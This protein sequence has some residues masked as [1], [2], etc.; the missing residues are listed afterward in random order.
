[1]AMPKKDQE[2]ATYAWMY[3]AQARKDG[4]EREVPAYWQEHANA[5]LQGFDGVAMDGFGKTKT[6]NDEMEAEVDEAA[7]ERPDE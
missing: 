4:K 1:M 6:V 3:G 2:R 5:W 7:V